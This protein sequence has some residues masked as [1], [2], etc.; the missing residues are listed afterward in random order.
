[1]Y[2]TL[3]SA[4]AGQAV[5]DEQISA[6]SRA[7]ID[8]AEAASDYGALKVIFGCFMVIFLLLILQQLYQQWELRK[9]LKSIE[10]ASE[11]TMEFFNDL[12][13]RTVGAQQ[14][15]LMVGE[16]LRKNEALVKYN[17]LKMRFENHLDDKERAEAKIRAIVDSL[18]TAQRAFLGNFYIRDRSISFTAVIEDNAA[19][20]KMMKEWVFMPDKDFTVSNMAQLIGIYYEGIRTKA[21][22]KIDG[23]ED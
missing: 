14:A 6:L 15:K 5:P 22:N 16:T 8:L 12:N 9:R 11:K 7:S 23:I 20:E 21:Y 13:N 19:L 17:I 3:L 18:F 1:M 10:E 4:A 2:V